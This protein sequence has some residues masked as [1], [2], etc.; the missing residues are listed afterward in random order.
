VRGSQA[1]APPADSAEPAKV[2]VT[3]PSSPRPPATHAE[4]RATP[5]KGLRLGLWALWRAVIRFL[6]RLTARDPGDAGS[7]DPTRGRR[8]MRD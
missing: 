8:P 6:H 2:A 5:V 1:D 7:K 4:L 3:P